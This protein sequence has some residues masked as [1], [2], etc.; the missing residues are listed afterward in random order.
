M[1]GDVPDRWITVGAT[2]VVGSGL[3]IMH[4]EARRR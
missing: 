1:W 2:L 3:Y 4:R